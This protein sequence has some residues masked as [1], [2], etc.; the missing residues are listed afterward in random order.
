M[1]YPLS[2]PIPFCFQFTTGGA[3]ATGLTVTVSVVRVTSAGVT[4]AVI[5]Q[6]SATAATEVSAT[7]AKG[8]YRYWLAGASTGVEG[9]YLATAHTSGTADLKD[10]PALEI[11]GAAW[12]TTAAGAMQAASYTAP[13]NAGITALGTA[14]GVVDDLLDTEIA[15]I[16]ASLILVKAKTDL[17]GAASVTVTSSVSSDGT[18]IS[19]LGGDD[20]HSVESREVEIVDTGGAWPDLTGAVVTFYAESANYGVAFTKAMTV[21]TPSGASKKIEIEFTAANTTTLRGQG[22]AGPG[23]SVASPYSIRAVLAT[24]PARTVTLVR[25][26]ISVTMVADGVNA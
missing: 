10:V 20:Y 22:G 21:V 7:D 11:V 15:A 23:V 3:G 6:A 18:N 8:L 12:V 4:T 9:V 17:I 13:D 25:G 14:L 24:T 19:L 26:S 1:L 5:T 2:A 16:I